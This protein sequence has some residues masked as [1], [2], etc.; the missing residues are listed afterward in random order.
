[1]FSEYV[2]KAFNVEETEWL[3][4][5]IDKKSFQQSVYE[6]LGSRNKLLNKGFP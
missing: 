5:K 1:M 3:F 4:I 2:K 6:N